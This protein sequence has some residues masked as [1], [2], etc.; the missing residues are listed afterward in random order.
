MVFGIEV[1][2]IAKLRHQLG[3]AAGMMEMLHV[4]LA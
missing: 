3:H 2:Q 1:D 4:M